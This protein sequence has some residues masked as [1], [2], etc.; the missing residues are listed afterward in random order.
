VE[1]SQ[2]ELQVNKKKLKNYLSKAYCSDILYIKY[3]SKKIRYIL[4]IKQ[5]KDNVHKNTRRV[6]SE[7]K[8]NKTE[9]VILTRPKN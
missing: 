9:K 1:N 3:A 7:K 2:K 5:E 4:N 8:E 6:I